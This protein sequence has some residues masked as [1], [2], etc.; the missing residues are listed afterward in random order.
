M[1]STNFSASVEKI[2]HPTI[3]I[4]WAIS[5][6]IPSSEITLKQSI[7]SLLISEVL[8]AANQLA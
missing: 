4:R 5:D 6:Y 3:K 7:F 8:R 2:C 1:I